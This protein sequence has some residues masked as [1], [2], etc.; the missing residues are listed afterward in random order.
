MREGHNVAMEYCS[1]NNGRC[2]RFALRVCHYQQCLRR[3]LNEE[4]DP[5][6]CACPIHTYLLKRAY[7]LDD[8]QAPRPPRASPVRHDQST[9]S[10]NKLHKQQAHVMPCIDSPHDSSRTN[11]RLPLLV[12]FGMIISHF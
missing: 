10:A 3:Y 11:L 1:V 6:R 4:R 5:R 2:G 12:D 7:A 9:C 8:F